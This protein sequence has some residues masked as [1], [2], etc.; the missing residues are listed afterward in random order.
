[1]STQS[2]YVSTA[3]PASLLPLL[4]KSPRKVGPVSLTLV[5]PALTPHCVPV[6][7]LVV[8]L[9]PVIGQLCAVHVRLLL[10]MGGFQCEALRCGCFCA[11]VP[12]NTCVCG[13]LGHIPRITVC[14]GWIHTQTWDFFYGIVFLMLSCMSSLYILDINLSLDISFTNTFSFSSCFFV[15]LMVSFVVQK[16]LNFM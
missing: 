15:L 2:Q 6:A 4:Q 10:D 9:G 12:G 3:W 14:P 5:A 16:L 11:C 13:S 7:G 1:M 8:T